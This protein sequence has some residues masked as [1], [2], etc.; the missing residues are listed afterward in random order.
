M[1]RLVD[2]S[3]AIHDGLAGVTRS[4]GDSTAGSVFRGWDQEAWPIAG[5]TGTAE[6][7]DKA[8]FSLFAAYGPL[9]DP[10]YSAFA[11]TQDRR[12]NIG[13]TLAGL[14]TFSNFLGAFGGNTGQ[15]GGFGARPF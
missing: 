15:G 12:F 4:G 1:P 14:G 6:V 2:L 11:V 13:F 7:N 5:K 9:G 8:D 10:Q 3:H